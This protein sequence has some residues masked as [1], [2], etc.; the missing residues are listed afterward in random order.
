MQRHFFG[1]GI[2]FMAVFGLLV[3]LLMDIFAGLG[4]RSNA[5]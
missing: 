1:N 4:L 5:L 3:H 2:A